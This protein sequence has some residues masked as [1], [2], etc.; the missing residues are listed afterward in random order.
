MFVDVCWTDFSVQNWMG[1]AATQ[2]NGCL[3]FTRRSSVAVA[4]YNIRC[5]VILHWDWSTSLYMVCVRV[6]IVLFHRMNY[7]FELSSRSVTCKTVSSWSE[8][9][10]CRDWLSWEPRSVRCV[11][12]CKVYALLKMSTCVCVKQGRYWMLSIR[13]PIVCFYFRQD[14]YPWFV[15]FI[16]L[17]H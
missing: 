12:L 15:A 9:I 16:C 8:F 1:L 14:L 6:Y 4:V 7:Y 3:V 11:G 13:K 17:P 2:L 10:R 5:A